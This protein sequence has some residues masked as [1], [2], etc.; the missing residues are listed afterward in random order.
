MTIAVHHADMLDWLAD[1]D[2]PLFDACVTDP[3]YHLTSIVK[4]FGKPGSAE[5]KVGATGAYARA[6]RGFMGKEWDGGDIAF[7]PETWAAVLA[8]MKPGAFLAA[9]GGTRTFHRLVCAIEDAGFEIRDQL[10]WCYASGF[11]KSHDVSKGIDRMA[12][13][14]REVIAAGNPVKRMIPG[15]DQAKA[16]WTKDNGREFVPTVTAPATDDAAHWQG[17]G[18]A[19]KPAWEPIVLARKPLCGTVAGNVLAHGTGAINID[20]CRIPTGDALGGGAEKITTADQKGNEG[21]TRPW[22]ADEAAQGAHASRVRTNV[23]RAEELG[24]WPANILH[25]GSDEVVSAFPIAPGQQASVR[26]DSGAGQKTDNILGAFRANS[27]CDPRG[28]TGSAARFFYSAKAG[29]LDRLGSAHATV[30]PVDLMRWLCRLVTPPGGLILDPFAGSGTTGIAAMADGFDCQMV[31]LEADHVAD[32]QRKLA[33]L[34]GEGRMAFREHDRKRDDTP[35]GAG[36]LF[37][38]IA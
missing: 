3:P 24:R 36:P 32:I 13:A 27:N 33:F 8:K 31:E 19:L 14:E 34:R 9:F 26:P 29:P 2:G 37:E 21:W 5:A 23:A 16:G 6:S 25:D 4:R 7:R 12:G 10:A 20:G 11:P 18:T 30:K 1:Y 35:Q 28:D 17:W 15:A 38:A 22:M